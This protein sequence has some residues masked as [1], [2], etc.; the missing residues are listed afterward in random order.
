MVVCIDKRLLG[1]KKHLIVESSES[2]SWSS[3]VSKCHD[4]LSGEIKDSDNCLDTI[5]MLES[6]KFPIEVP[7]QYVD[8]ARTVLGQKYGHVD[9]PWQDFMPVDIHRNFMMKSVQSTLT[10]IDGLSKQYF[11]DV[12]RQSEKLFKSLRPAF[13]DDD[14]LRESIDEEESDSQISALRSFS[15]DEFGFVEPPLYNRVGT[16]TGRLTV[17]K[18]PQI[19]TI[20]K[21][22]RNVIRSSYVSGSIISMDFIALEAR[23]AYLESHSEGL[24]HPDVYESINSDHFKGTLDRNV[25][26]LAVLCD[27]FGMGAAGLA[28]KLG[29]SVQMATKFIEKLRKLF[30]TDELTSRLRHEF[31]QEG[32]IRNRFG[33]RVTVPEMRLLLNSFVQSTG[34][35][36]A[37][38]GFKALIDR[39]SI[40]CPD[41]RPL[42]ILH[43]DLLVDCPHRC[44]ESLMKMNT[45]AVRGYS[46]PFHVKVKLLEVDKSED[47][48]ST[49]TE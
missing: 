36:V 29:V 1:T 38:L 13:I 46:T 37:L 30:R 22:Y 9:V 23:V 21:S 12:W 18:G 27:L 43:D 4:H 7:K 25:V 35:D 45:I 49:I 39:M 16:R 6:V 10:A 26:K 19:L 3:D 20:K 31:V 42:M 11:S 24:I 47:D 2:L 14:F 32:F 40:E 8:A 44:F 41:V 48:G 28:S 15:P 17:E 34:V 33:R 5:L